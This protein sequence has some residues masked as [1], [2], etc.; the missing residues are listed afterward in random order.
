MKCQFC[1]LEIEE[2][3]KKCQHCLSF[4]NLAVS[5]KR[6]D[7]ANLIISFIGIITIAFTLT[8]GI[9]GY[10]GFKS[11][12]DLRAR[13]Q[14]ILEKSDKAIDEFKKEHTVIRNSYLK[15]IN[16]FEKELARLRDSYDK[17]SI[18]YNDLLVMQ[19]WERF[20][21]LLDRIELDKIEET[22]LIADEVNKIARD[23][24]IE[25]SL[26]ES[27][28]LI[29]AQ[30]LILANAIKLYKE[31]DYEGTK[32]AVIELED[33]NIN[34]HRFLTCVY[35]KLHKAYYLKNEEKAEFCLKGVLRHSKKYNQLALH[36]NKKAIIGKV[37]RANA[38]LIRNDKGDKEEALAL[39]DQAIREDPY[40]ATLFANRAYLRHLMEEE[41]QAIKDLKRAFE[42]GHFKTLTAKERFRKSFPDLINSKNP[43]I[44]KLI[45]KLLDSG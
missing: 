7:T 26:S 35:G 19:L 33:S 44:N 45:K 40:R 3:A 1:G 10:I 29:R 24:N 22:E 37:N 17:T 42:L 43:E 11:L 41:D 14:S 38:L 21:H 20:Q 34:K 23:V 4:Q 25:T 6:Y 5:K 30:I 9:S 8:L 12:T 15:K 39:Y 32:R 16:D 2:T 31:N 36:L 18:A 28:R 13:S 27:S